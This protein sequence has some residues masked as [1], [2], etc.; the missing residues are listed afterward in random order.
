MP[1]VIADTSCLIVLDKSESLSILE[2]M[3]GNLLVTPTVKSEY[4]KEL[5][6]FVGV[7]TVRNPRYGMLLRSMLDPGEA[8]TLAL[9]VEVEDPSCP[10]WTTATAISGTSYRRIRSGIGEPDLEASCPVGPSLLTGA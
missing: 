6:S 8:S 10:S 3:Y 5:P 7:R 1:N 4:G 2:Q 9:A